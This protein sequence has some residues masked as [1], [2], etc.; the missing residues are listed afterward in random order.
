VREIRLHG[1]EGGGTEI[2][3]FFLP[4]SKNPVARIRW[5][6]RGARTTI[7]FLSRSLAPLEWRAAVVEVGFKPN[8]VELAVTCRCTAI[9]DPLPLVGEAQREGFSSSL[10]PSPKG[11]GASNMHRPRVCCSGPVA[12]LAGVRK[13]SPCEP[14]QRGRSTE[15]VKD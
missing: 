1:S 9:Y 10:A 2:N 5:R 7:R 12:S 8:A 3:R 14:P 13:T 6:T 15:R 4:L 11:E